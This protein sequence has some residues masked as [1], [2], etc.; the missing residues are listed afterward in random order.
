VSS[1]SRTARWP[2]SS[3]EEV[4]HGY[5]VGDMVTVAAR[6]DR[7]DI[8]AGSR[9]TIYGLFLDG[10][11]RPIIGVHL[12]ALRMTALY[13]ANELKPVEPAEDLSR[14]AHV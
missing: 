2:R 10:H 11:D 13:Y 1:A 12:T 4:D 5:W 6:A 9:G 8:P 7:L 14:S 3:E